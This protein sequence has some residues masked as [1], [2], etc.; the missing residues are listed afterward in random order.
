MDVCQAEGKVLNCDKHPV[1]IANSTACQPGGKICDFLDK[2]FLTID[3]KRHRLYASYT[4]FPSN[5]T[6]PAPAS[7]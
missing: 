7:T 2:D 6:T 5:A 1:V 4:D 3:P